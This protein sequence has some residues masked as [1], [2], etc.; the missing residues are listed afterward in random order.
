MKSMPRAVILSALLCI[1]P[2]VAGDTIKASSL[3]GSWL[4][5]LKLTPGAE[6]RVVFN[7]TA[8]PDGSLSGT[9]DS[10]DQGATGIPVT[11]ITFEN[12]RLHIGVDS[13]MGAF[14]GTPSADGSEISGQWTQGGVSLPLALKPVKEAPKPQRPQEPKKPYPYVSEDVTYQN[15][16]ASV[17]LAGTLTMPRTGGPFP[18]VILISGSGSQDRDETVFGH[19]PFLVLA[20]YLTRRGI[21]VLRV[22]DRG[23]GGSKGDV[24]QATSE[25]FT[26]DVLAGVGYLKTRRQIDPGRIGLIGHSEGGCIAPMAAVKSSDVSFIVL[27]AGTGV[28]GDLVIESQIAGS[29]KAGGVDQA[30]IDSA[31]DDQRRI[32]AVVRTETNPDLAKEKI[33]RIIVDAL[34][35]LDEERK[36]AIGDHDAYVNAQVKAA[37]SPWFRFFVTHDP[38]ETLREVK[39]P[40]LAVNGSLDVQVVASLNLPAIEQALRAGKNPDFTV[41]ELPGLNHLF[42]TAK[43]GGAE[44]YARIEETLSPVAME[45]VAKWIEDRTKRK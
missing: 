39:C 41:K 36:R 9:L 20:D 11:K 7:L 8:K 45:T 44:E 21:A 17:T 4:G 42:Q 12:G 22:D 33:R 43:T 29:L 37:T 32:D 38:K 6:L 1:V 26:R 35:K 3:A 5:T 15:A 30:R 27:L 2:V 34:S 19:R 10:P 23:V 28:T 18:A 24:A 31:I 14:E 16:K 25:D 40:V 13:V